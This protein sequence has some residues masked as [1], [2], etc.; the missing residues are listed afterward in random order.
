MG[1]RGIDT[2]RVRVWSD[3]M[4]PSSG[5]TPEEQMASGM[6]F[7]AYMAELIAAHRAD[8]CEGLIGRWW[9]GRS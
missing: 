5:I 6:E 4:L 3:N 1:L 2:D 9:L 7:Y 8:P